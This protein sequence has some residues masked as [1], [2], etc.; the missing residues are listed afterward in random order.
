[1]EIGLQYR[2][3]YITGDIFSPKYHERTGT[4]IRESIDKKYYIFASEMI[5]IAKFLVVYVLKTDILERLSEI[6]IERHIVDMIS[7]FVIKSAEFI[8]VRLNTHSPIQ[9]IDFDKLDKFVYSYYLPGAGN[10]YLEVEQS[11]NN[12]LK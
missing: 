5:D 9:Y 1:M 6:E 7:L 8:T 3:K 4:Y 10:G 2:Y 11:W 12:S